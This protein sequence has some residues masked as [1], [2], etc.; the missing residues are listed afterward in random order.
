MVS[1]SLESLVVPIA[2]AIL[3]ALFAIQRFG[4]GAVGRLFGP[5]MAVWFTV[6]AVGGIAQ[7][8][9]HP[10]ILRALSPSYAAQFFVDH[11]GDGVHRAGRGGA[12]RDRR[13][14][15]VRRHGPLRAP[16]DPARVVLPRLPRADRSTTSARAR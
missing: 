9:Q 14:G 6:L 2:L 1:P 11:G 16:P 12:G 7:V 8:A 13:G 15:A 4:T 5:V 10:G 3:T